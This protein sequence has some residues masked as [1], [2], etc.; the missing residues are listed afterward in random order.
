MSTT[1]VPIEVNDLDKRIAENQKTLNQIGQKY[2]FPTTIASVVLLIV[3]WAGA[4][5]FASDDYWMNLLT[6]GIGIAI[7]VLIIDRLNEYR[8][9]QRLKRRLIREAGGD[10]N[11]LA[12]AA[13]DWMRAEGWA[14]GENSLLKGAHL[15][16]ANLCG[17]N[18]GNLNLSSVN[19][20]LARLTECNLQLANLNNAKMVSASLENAQLG[21]ADLRNATLAFANLERANVQGANLQ[22]TNMQYANLQHAQLGKADLHGANL[23]HANMKYAVLIGTM[24]HPPD[25]KMSEY[26]ATFDEET[27]LPDGSYWTPDT[28]MTRFTNP[29]HRNF[30]K[31][32][33]WSD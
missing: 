15:F 28:D 25:F 21:N 7:T 14:R 24:G 1:S 23:Q 32:I 5:R 31:A 9:E 30:W 12:K 3:I 16:A 18:L 17:A 29:K 8:E 26:P 22:K 11:E 20:E 6:E 19:L 10:A 4:K 27:I 2:V 33:I 13:I